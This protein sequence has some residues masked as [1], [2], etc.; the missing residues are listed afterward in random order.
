MNLDDY[1]S[2]NLNIAEIIRNEW[3]SFPEC[4]STIIAANNDHNNNHSKFDDSVVNEIV[5]FLVFNSS[6][7]SEQGMQHFIK[8]YLNEKI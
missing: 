2:K 8:N 3:K 5:D 7:N 1:F 6:E 4:E